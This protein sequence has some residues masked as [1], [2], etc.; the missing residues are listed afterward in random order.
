MVNKEY[1]IELNERREAGIAL[2]WG[3]RAISKTP[4]FKHFHVLTYI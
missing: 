4:N 1:L 2:V 3:F